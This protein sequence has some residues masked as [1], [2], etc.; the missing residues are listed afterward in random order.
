[1]LVMKTEITELKDASHYP[2]GLDSLGAEKNEVNQNYD[3]LW[4]RH[5]WVDWVHQWHLKSTM[6]KVEEN[7]ERERCVIKVKAREFEVGRGMTLKVL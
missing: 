6:I 7:Q 1:M 5:V 4:D 3:A 2:Q